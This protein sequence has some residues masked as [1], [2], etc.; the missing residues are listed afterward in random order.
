MNLK[1]F[2]TPGELGQYAGKLTAEYLNKAIKER[3]EARLVVSTG[4]SQFETLEALRGADVDWSKVTMFHLDEYIGLDETHKA[5]FVKYL[6]ERFTGFLPKMKAHYVDGTKNPEDVIKKLTEEINK[7]PVDIA[8]IG[9]GVNAHVAFNDPPA[10][11]DTKESY[12]VV[13]LDNVCK[14]QQVGE[15]W[16]ATVADVPDIALTMTVHKVMQSK[17]IISAVPHAVKADAVY[18][19]VNREVTNTVPATI[20]KNHP[21]WTLCVDKNSASKLEKTP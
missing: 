7:A 18:N 16:F 11:F 10:D 9:I 3:G 14:E 4:M 20:L 19:T 21:D 8:L 13:K 6:K 1:I 5:S 12:I 15:G 17:A 2:E